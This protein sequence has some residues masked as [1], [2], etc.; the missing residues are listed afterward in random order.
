M[1]LLGWGK[2]ARS[3]H[4]T[5]KGL[6]DSEG[7]SILMY[8]ARSP[9][10]KFPRA[11]E[12]RVGPRTRLGDRDRAAALQSV[13]W[14]LFPPEVR[15]FKYYCPQLRGARDLTGESAEKRA[16]PIPYSSKTT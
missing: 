5:A 4:F 3:A 8:T 10:Q 11:A 14:I 7:R 9:G 1:M 6:E 13:P 12:L 16:E 2:G 15:G